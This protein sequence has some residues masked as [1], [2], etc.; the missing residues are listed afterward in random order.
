MPET[1]KR[2]ENKNKQVVRFFAALI[3]SSKKYFSGL[4]TTLVTHLRDTKLSLLREMSITS[5]VRVFHMV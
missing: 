2:I 3:I 1:K 4:L 5:W